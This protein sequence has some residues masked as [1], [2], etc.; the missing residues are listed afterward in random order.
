MTDKQRE[1]QKRD[2]EAA[3]L[4]IEKGIIKID[5]NAGESKKK[6]AY[7]T[8]IRNKDKKKEQKQEQ[9]V[10][11]IVE[12]EILEEGDTRHIKKE[13]EDIVDD[14][15]NDDSEVVPNSS[16]EE[17]KKQVEEISVHDTSKEE[18]KLKES[19]K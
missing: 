11:E 16:K 12:Q 13:E 4:L 19:R 2:M 8:R 3:K 15:E 10:E 14:W 6:G 9:V 1:N 18:A 5:E 17:E 7:Q